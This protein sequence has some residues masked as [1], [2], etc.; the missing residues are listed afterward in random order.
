MKN[1]Q[2]TIPQIK[3]YIADENVKSAVSMV[4]RTFEK[5]EGG[6]HQND[7]VLIE[8][9]DGSTM[10][11]VRDGGWVEND[12]ERAQRIF[13]AYAR[14]ARLSEDHLSC[15]FVSTGINPGLQII[16]QSPK[17]TPYGGAICKTDKGEFVIW[18]DDPEG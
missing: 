17:G 4:R 6:Q 18:Y 14:E 15:A 8:F 9:K 5:A 13:R 1:A 3:T 11:L 12:D 10:R 16:P 7:T 2:L